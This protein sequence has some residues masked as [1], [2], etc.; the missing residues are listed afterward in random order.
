MLNLATNV[1]VFR[2]YLLNLMRNVISTNGESAVF[3]Y[4]Y[5]NVSN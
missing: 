5:A 4:V 1:F 2:G 3:S